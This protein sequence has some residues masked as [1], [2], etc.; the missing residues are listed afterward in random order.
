[1]VNII[2]MDDITAMLGIIDQNCLDIENVNKITNYIN[3]TRWDL[4]RHVPSLFS[5]PFGH[6]LHWNDLLL[7]FSTSGVTSVQFV[8]S[9]QGL[10]W[11]PSKSN[12]H[13]SPDGKCENINK[14]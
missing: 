1:M 14:L 10:S 2:M 9:V 13:W 5:V 4:R 7:D 11:Q 12:S 6:W 3:T 8:P